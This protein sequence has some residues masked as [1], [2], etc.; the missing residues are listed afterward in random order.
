MKTG[1]CCVLYMFYVLQRTLL[2]IHTDPDA[3]VKL[4]GCQ[5]REN[6]LLARCSFL[7]GYVSVSKC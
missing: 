7:H 3:A 1:Y 2:D 6:S 4:E 5:G